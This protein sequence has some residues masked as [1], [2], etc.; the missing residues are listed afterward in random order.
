MDAG[1][2]VV[3]Q[4]G[5][6]ATGNVAPTHLGLKNS[7]KSDSH[8]CLVLSL[9]PGSV[10]LGPSRTDLTGGRIPVGK[11]NSPTVLNTVFNGAGRGRGNREFDGTSDSHESSY[12]SRY[13]SR[14]VCRHVRRNS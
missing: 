1:N 11:R 8:G 3:G 12:I 2:T 4:G 14:Y 7:S 6:D 9:G 13:A 5:S 10:G